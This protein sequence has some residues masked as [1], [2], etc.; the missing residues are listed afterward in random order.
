V[1][2]CTAVVAAPSSMGG[3][4]LAGRQDTEQPGA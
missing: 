4:A 3:A 2:V 1:D